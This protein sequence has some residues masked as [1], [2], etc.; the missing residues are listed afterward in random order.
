[1]DG[2]G[3]V[4]VKKDRIKSQAAPHHVMCTIFSDL[5]SFPLYAMLC[6]SLPLLITNIWLD[7]DSDLL[8]KNVHVH[9]A[10]SVSV[11]RVYPRHLRFSAVT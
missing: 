2:D 10:V 3:D 1:M 5:L 4:V 9:L 8:L 6:I 11:S 7:D